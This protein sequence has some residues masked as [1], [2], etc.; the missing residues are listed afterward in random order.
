MSDA[1]WQLAGA[2]LPPRLMDV[3][4]TVQPGVTAIMGPSG[5]GKTT[6]LNLLVGFESSSVGRVTTQPPHMFWSPQHHGLWPHRSARQQLFAVQSDATRIDA[7]LDAFDLA[8]RADA[9]PEELSKG[10]AGR[11]SIA[12]A[13]LSDAP[14]LVFDEP[15]GHVDTARV[16]RYWQ[17][18]REHIAAQGASLIFATHETQTVLAEAPRVVYLRGGRL[19]YDGDVATLYHQPATPQLADAFG[20]H[21]WFEADEAKQWLGASAP[22]A[23]RCVRPERLAVEPGGELTV[24]DSRFRG[25]VTETTLALDGEQRRVVH[26]SQSN[27]RCGAAV[28]LRLLTL[29]LACVLAGCFDGDGERQVHFSR[30][31]AFTLPGVEA[32]LPAP[33]AVGTGRDGHW[34]ALDTVG[35]V[36]EFDAECQLVR[37]WWMPEHDIG[38]PEDVVLLSDGRIAVADTHYHR[39]VLFDEQGNV[40]SMFGRG[41]KGQG[42]FVY[43]SAICE[44]DR[45]RLFVAEYG[46][47]NDR[48]QVFDRDG[49]FLYQFGGF[50]TGAGEFQR[51]TGVVWHEGKVYVSDATNH[52]V[53]VFSDDGEFENYLQSDQ[54]PW[55]IEYPYHMDIGPDQ[56]LWLIEWGADRITRI[57]LDG[58]LLG[59]YGRSGQG[60]GEFSR[61]WGIAV[62]DRG[63]VLVGDTRNRR[64]V[65]LRP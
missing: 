44:D 52:R 30:F 33:R 39:I 29:L 61:P 63:R 36:I 25:A 8:H 4:L 40:L 58:R 41:G 10:E 49:A 56:T 14:V 17:V 15:L 18:I 59:R 26:R 31:H 3:T 62:S 6:L 47:R 34:Y 9:Q 46:S 37:S 28:A 32:N 11:L 35:R 65:E 24:V 5:A 12:R 21:N 23:I 64:L 60:E 1:L 43:P 48:V 45:G 16:G 51:P 20:P 57:G 2:G 27:L 19:Q 22:P 50:G 53:H 55:R 54:E 7:M 38:R 13:L 42:Q